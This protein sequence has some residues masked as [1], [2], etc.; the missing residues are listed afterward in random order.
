MIFDLKFHIK[1]VIYK[2]SQLLR[3]NRTQ[4]KKFFNKENIYSMIG[5]GEDYYILYSKDESDCVT[6]VI[7]KERKVGEI[8]GIG[9]FKSC[10]IDSNTKVGST[11]LKIT[12]KMLKKYKDTFG[13]NKIV[14]TDNSVKNANLIE[15]I[16]NYH[17][18]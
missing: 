6:V 17:I 10:L 15:K 9:N 2:N 13:I 4:I 1:K 18:C 8:H 12:I 14:L 5:G 7:D 3:D 11:L 16:L